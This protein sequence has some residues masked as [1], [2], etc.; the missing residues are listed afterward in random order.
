M[1]LHEIPRKS[2]IYEPCSDGSTYFIYDH[3][4]GMYSYCVTE[5]GAIVHLGLAQSLVAFEDGYKFGKPKQCKEC[6]FEVYASEQRHSQGC[7]Q[8]GIIKE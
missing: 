5:K 4:D 2:K 3:P 6:Q 1:F 7:S 8:Y